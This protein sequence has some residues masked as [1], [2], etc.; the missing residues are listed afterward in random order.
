MGDGAAQPRAHDDQRVLGGVGLRRARLDGPHGREEPN[1]GG[2]QIA[3]AE[4]QLAGLHEW[5]ERV[6]GELHGPRRCVLGAVDVREREVRA[7]QVGPRV[8]VVGL[9]GDDGQQPVATV[10]PLLASQRP[11]RR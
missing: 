6:R 5:G 8:G 9:A 1:L 7:R 3:E 11:E 2:L 4:G 10:G